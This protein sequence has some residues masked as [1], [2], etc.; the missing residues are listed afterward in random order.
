MFFKVISLGLQT[1][2]K[3][4][5]KERKQAMLAAQQFMKDKGYS[6]KTQVCSDLQTEEMLVQFR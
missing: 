4:N 5:E 3:A 1:G 6:Q 2:P